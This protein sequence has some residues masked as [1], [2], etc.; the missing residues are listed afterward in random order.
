ME[1]RLNGTPVNWD[2]FLWSRESPIYRESTVSHLITILTGHFFHRDKLQIFYCPSD[3]ETNNLRV[4]RCE[5]GLF[6]GTLFYY[7]GQRV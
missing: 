1:L 5:K 4:C 6:T 2:Y 3:S 7:K